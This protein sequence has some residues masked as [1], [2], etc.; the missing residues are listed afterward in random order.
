M[1]TR[2]PGASASFPNGQ[3]RQQVQRDWGNYASAVTLPNA[4][5]NLLSASQFKLEEG[6]VAFVSSIGRFF[7]S[8]AGTPG[9]GDAVWVQQQQ[10]SA[11][12][13]E[14]VANF[15]AAP[16]TNYPV[17][18]TGGAITVALPAVPVVDDTFLLVDSRATS[19]T[20]AIIIDFIAAGALLHGTV[21]VV[22][23]QIDQDY[24]SMRFVFRGGAIGWLT[25]T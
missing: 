24:N 1:A 8:S 10:E 9:G 2:T 22:N 17:N 11:W 21:P 20:N 7:C 15:T 6:D 3:D 23:P 4:S 5:G 25:V 12:A 16:Y 14:Q 13:A 18:T 19:G